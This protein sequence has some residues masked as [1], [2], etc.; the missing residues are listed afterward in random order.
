MSREEAII[1][2]TEILDEATESEDA[3]CYVTLVDAPQLRM[4]IEALKR[5]EPMELIQNEGRIDPVWSMDSYLCPKC[6]N[7][8]G[9]HYRFCNKCGQA[10]KGWGE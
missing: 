9:Q 7:W 6:H 10:V 2:L 4:A 1:K 3:V 8:I 5:E